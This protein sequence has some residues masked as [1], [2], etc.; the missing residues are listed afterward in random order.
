MT[1][2]ADIRTELALLRDEVQFLRERLA[3]HVGNGLVLTYLADG[4]PFYVNGDDF[5]GPANLIAGGRYEQD[6]LDILLSF[7]KPETVFLDVG[8]NLGFFA[9]MVAQRLTA[10]RVIAVEPHPEL[11]HLAWRN[12]FVNGL[13]DRVTVAPCGASD[14]EAAVTFA[15][16]PHH[17][18]GGAIGRAGGPGTTV[19][20][21]VRP[22]DAIVPQDLVC[23]LVKIDVEGHELP[24]LRGMA[25]IIR[26]SPGIAILFEKLGLAAGYEDELAAFLAGEGLS[27]YAARPGARLAPLAAADLPAFSGY[28]LATRRKIGPEDRD[29][30]RFTIHPAQMWRPPGS[31]LATEATGLTGSGEGNQ[32][33]SHGP[34]WFL[35]RGIWEMRLRG[36]LPRGTLVRIT[37]H[38]GHST[39]EAM[40]EGTDPCF[41]ATVLRDLVNFETVIRSPERAWSITVEGI[42]FV[43]RG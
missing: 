38:M 3:V 13:A 39:F 40:V 34:Y 17:L 31:P 7:L 33:V 10:G 6:N 36:R 14:R 42:D 8:A 23:D 16:P 9:V 35:P 15:Y 24:V 11:A 41:T 22:L 18:G 20:G 4:R 12:A 27:L 2:L 5:G 37:S 25:G 32:L 28:V 30:R 1:D 19:S 26:R 21:H 43:R 29:R